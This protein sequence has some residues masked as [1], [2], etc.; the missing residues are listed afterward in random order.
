MNAAFG[1]N[2]LEPVIDRVFAFGDAPD[3]FR[4]M[5]AA[6]HFGKLVVRVD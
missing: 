4:A 1:A 2:R 6:G 5:Q 3:A